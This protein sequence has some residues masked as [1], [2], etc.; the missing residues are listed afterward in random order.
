MIKK[1]LLITAMFT[2]TSVWADKIAFSCVELTNNPFKEPKILNISIDTKA[3][4]VTQDSRTYD[5]KEKGDE[6]IWRIRGGRFL[7]NRMTGT[8]TAQYSQS[9]VWVTDSNLK[10]EKGDK[11]F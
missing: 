6:I 11:L 9:M 5:Y 8:V 7:M 1:L 3:K 4:T 2:A 10:C